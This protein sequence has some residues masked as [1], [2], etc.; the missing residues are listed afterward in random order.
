MRFGD[1]GELRL[2]IAVQDHMV[3]VAA[4]GAGGVERLRCGEIDEAAAAFRVVGIEDGLDLVGG[5]LDR[6]AGEKD[7]L[8]RLI[9]QF[10][11]G[12]HGRR[13]AAGA[14]QI[15]LV[16]PALGGALDLAEQMHLGRFGRVAELVV[17]KMLGE[18]IADLARPHRFQHRRGQLHPFADDAFQQHAAR[19]DLLRRQFQARVSR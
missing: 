18:M 9:R 1:P 14:D 3:D 2:P 6:L 11:I 16:D 15:A 17:E 5:R 10:Q 8:R 19:P 7:Q 4:R 13:G 12:D